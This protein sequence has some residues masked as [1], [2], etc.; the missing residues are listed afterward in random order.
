MAWCGRQKLNHGF[1]VVGDFKSCNDPKII[2]F[3]AHQDEKKVMKELG[4][5]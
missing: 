3:I 4:L 5:V 1:F 2:M